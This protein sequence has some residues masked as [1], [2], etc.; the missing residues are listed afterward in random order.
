MW[1]P[2]QLTQAALGLA[3][4]RDYFC[5]L[6]ARIVTQGQ[7]GAGSAITSPLF[8]VDAFW[9]ERKGTKHVTRL[10]PHFMRDLVMM[11]IQETFEPE[12]APNVILMG[13]STHQH[14]S[15]CHASFGGT[16][17]IH[18][19]AITRADAWREQRVQHDPRQAQQQPAADFPL[20][21][22][23]CRRP[24]L[25]AQRRAVWAERRVLVCSPEDQILVAAARGVNG[26]GSFGF[27]A[28]FISGKAILE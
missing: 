18:A 5:H 13:G 2:L 26:R 15:I 16:M 17:R 28:L 19:L 24:A 23:Q 3:C 9:H 10:R 7:A 14:A 27:P 21:P 12:L 11:L 4:A 6:K 1:L 8:Q 22:R 25:S 20:C